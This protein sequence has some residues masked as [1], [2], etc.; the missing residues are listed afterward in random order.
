MVDVKEI[1]KPFTINGNKYCFYVSPI[2]EKV[3]GSEKEAYSVIAINLATMKS[4]TPTYFFS[5]TLIEE[6]IKAKEK[7]TDKI[8]SEKI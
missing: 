5:D 6:I 2:P 4:T 8:Y 1:V 3:L 7:T